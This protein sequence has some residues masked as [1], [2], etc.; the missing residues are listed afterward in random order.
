MRSWSVP[1]CPQM[2]LKHWIQAVSEDGE[3]GTEEGS[4]KG[5]ISLHLSALT[6]WLLDKTGGRQGG[7]AGGRVYISV[8]VFPL[9]QYLDWQFQCNL[10]SP[11]PVVFKISRVGG[12]VNGSLLQ[13]EVLFRQVYQPFS[14]FSTS[15]PTDK[16]LKSLRCTI[17]FLT[18]DKGHHAAGDNDDKWPF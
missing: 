1:A 9:I 17:R 15:W 2:Q 8:V 5:K 7:R 13:I 3:T 10:S 4:R 11:T 16:V 14:T 18:N 6:I 12:V